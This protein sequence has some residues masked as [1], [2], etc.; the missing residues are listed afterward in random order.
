MSFVNQ[1]AEIVHCNVVKYGGF[2]NKNIG[3]A[4]LFVWKFQ[5]SQGPLL[6]ILDKSNFK[7]YVKS[8]PFS[9][10]NEIMTTCDLA[11]YSVLKI[12]CHINT[13]KQILKYRKQKEMLSRIPDYKVQMGFGL[14]LGW[15]IEGLIGS[16]YKIDASYLSPNVNIAA[17]LEAATK[18]YGTEFLISG[19]LYHLMSKPFRSLCRQIDIASV[20]G[21]IKPIHLYTIDVDTEI[22]PP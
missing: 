22:L 13:F 2:P 16:A 19:Q 21:S 4:F 3:D 11:I 14:H 18:Q 10:Q 6:Q 9:L 17:R 5:R 7:H 20:K 8:L 15:A 1:I 12:I